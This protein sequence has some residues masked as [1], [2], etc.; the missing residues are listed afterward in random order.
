MYF[1]NYFI[2]TCQQNRRKTFKLRYFK[3]YMLLTALVVKSLLNAVF[4][5]EDFVKDVEKNI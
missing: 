2:V 5:R 3:I 4:E 1:Q